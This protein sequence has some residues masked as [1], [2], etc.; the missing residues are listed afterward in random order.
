MSAGGIGIY[1][2]SEKNFGSAVIASNTPDIGFLET[3]RIV[4]PSLDPSG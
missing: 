3:K 4:S 2:I 1:Q